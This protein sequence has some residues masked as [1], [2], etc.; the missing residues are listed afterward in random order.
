MYGAINLLF[1]PLLKFLGSPNCSCTSSST[2]FQSFSTTKITSGAWQSQHRSVLYSAALAEGMEIVALSIWNTN[3]TRDFQ[4]TVDRT[5]HGWEEKGKISDSDHTISTL[6]SQHSNVPVTLPAPY[7]Q[8]LSSTFWRSSFHHRVLR[9]VAISRQIGKTGLS[10]CLLTENELWDD[11]RQAHGD[12][13]R[14]CCWQAPPIVHSTCVPHAGTRAH[15]DTD[16]WCHAA[17]WVHPGA[18]GDRRSICSLEN[19]FLALMPAF[20]AKSTEKS[21]LM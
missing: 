12:C 14:A 6:D 1:P 11:T 4:H 10:P 9:R 20:E 21:L 19:P 2:P 16:V 7:S 8:G 3:W 18:Q 17:G 13:I 15:T 5:A